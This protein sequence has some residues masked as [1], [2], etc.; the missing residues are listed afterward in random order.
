M[1]GLVGVVLML[2]NDFIVTWISPLTNMSDFTQKRVKHQTRTK[3]GIFP[4]P[5]NGYCPVEC[6][7]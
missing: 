7:K 6:Q 5:A 1:G 3:K 2:S 4:L